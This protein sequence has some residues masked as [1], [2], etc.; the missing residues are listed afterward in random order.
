MEK[1]KIS[2]FEIEIL[3]TQEIEIQDI[4]QSMTPKYSQKLYI[5]QRAVDKDNDVRLLPAYLKKIFNVGSCTANLKMM[6]IRVVLCTCVRGVHE[7]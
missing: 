6:H 5:K 3:T 4:L 2:E 1:Q 7:F